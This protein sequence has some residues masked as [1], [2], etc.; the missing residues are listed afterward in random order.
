MWAFQGTPI[1]GV[2][3]IATTPIS[4]CVITIPDDAVE[5][6]NPTIEAKRGGFQPQ[7]L[8]KFITSSD[9]TY[10]LIQNYS[11]KTSFVLDTKGGGEGSH[12]VVW[13]RS[14]S[15]NQRFYMRMK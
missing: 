1:P 8:W 6:S 15:N 2:F 5:G 3:Y 12:V 11:E 7:Q 14:D 4:G 13:N 9:G 10:L